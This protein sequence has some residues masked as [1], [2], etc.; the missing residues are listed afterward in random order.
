MRPRGPKKPIKPRKPIG[1]PATRNRDKLVTLG[2]QRDREVQRHSTKTRSLAVQ[3]DAAHG[4]ADPA[5]RQMTL[6]RLRYD[7]QE[8]HN[9]HRAK[10]ADFERRFR[11]ARS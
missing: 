10:M 2:A 11:E 1:T 7:Q 9:R 3:S 5:L 4:I 8:E 6:A